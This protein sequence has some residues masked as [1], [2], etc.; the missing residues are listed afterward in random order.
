MRAVA[1]APLG[2]TRLAQRKDSSFVWNRSR[3]V[4]L[5]YNLNGGRLGQA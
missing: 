4:E 3:A 2:G 5:A 1:L